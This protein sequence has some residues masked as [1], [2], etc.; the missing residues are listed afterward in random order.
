MFNMNQFFVRM[1]DANGIGVDAPARSA[2]TV[3]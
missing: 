3:C 1:R 2:P